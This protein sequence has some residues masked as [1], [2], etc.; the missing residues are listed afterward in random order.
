MRILNKFKM[1]DGCHFFCRSMLCKR[2]LC[3]HAVSV[4]LSVTFVYSVKTSNHILKL[5]HHR[6]ATP[7]Y[8]FC[9][10]LYGNI[11]TG[12]PNCGVECRAYDFRPISPRLI[13]EMIQD[14]AIVTTERIQE[15]VCG[16]PNGVTSNDTESP[17]T[18][19]S[20]SCHYLTLFCWG[21]T[22]DVGGR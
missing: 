11:P 17:L 21:N 13:S 22:H 8:F 15:L 6:V 3:R 16:L 7:V 20:R 12:T 1:A 4:R 19:I 10:K 9:T 2:G 5:F 14:M 18:R